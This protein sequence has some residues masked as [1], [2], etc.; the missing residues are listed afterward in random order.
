MTRQ[1]TR[2]TSDEAV[3]AKNHQ[4]PRRRRRLALIQQVKAGWGVLLFRYL[5]SFFWKVFWTF[6]PPSLS[7][8]GEEMG[9]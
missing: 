9:N 1:L 6:F 4:E 2:A 3:L 5:F 7:P 8:L